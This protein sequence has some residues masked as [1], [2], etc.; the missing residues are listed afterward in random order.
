MA[1]DGSEMEFS[2]FEES[3]D[4]DDGMV[5][6]FLN[7]LDDEDPTDLD[8][9]TDFDAVDDDRAELT[10]GEAAEAP[11]EVKPSAKRPQEF[12][13]MTGNREQDR[14]RLRELAAKGSDTELDAVLDGTLRQSDYSKKTMSL[15]DELRATKAQQQELAAAMAGINELKQSVAAVAKPAGPIDIVTDPVGWAQEY[16]RTHGRE[17][18]QHDYTLAAAEAKIQQLLAQEVAPLRQQVQAQVQSRVEKETEAQWNELVTQYPFL[19]TPE[20]MAEIAEYVRATNTYGAPNF[21][22][23]AAWAVKGEELAEARQSAK[24]AAVSKAKASVPPTPS[25]TPPAQRRAGRSTS[26]FD[27]IAANQRKNPSIR[28]L[29]RGGGRNP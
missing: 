1:I 12:E 27:Q 26:S 23:S 7:G 22:R 14:A 2:R 24:A 10:E 8:D 17:P 13:W 25:P 4:L 15:A 3:D 21:L 29:L 28:N 5:D 19:N 11:E 20:A 16:E 6:R 18:S 9:D